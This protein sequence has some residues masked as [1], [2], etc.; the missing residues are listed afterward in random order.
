MARSRQS[1]ER[2]RELGVLGEQTA[3]D[4]LEKK[5]YRIV[6]RNYRCRMGEIDLVADRD[7][8]LVFVEVKS[9]HASFPQVNPLISLTKAKCN[10]LR[11]VGRVYLKHRNIRHKQPRFDVIGIIFRNDQ[12]YTLEH[13]EN[14]F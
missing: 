9:R 3:A 4:F 7:E 2:S 11:L 8:Y 6:E 12:G 5:G 10:R 1:A 13:I 14:A